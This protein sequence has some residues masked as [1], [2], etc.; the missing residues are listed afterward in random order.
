MLNI[1]LACMCAIVSTFGINFT[2]K[3]IIIFFM[4]YSHG[5]LDSSSRNMYIGREK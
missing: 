2:H 3:N 4:F 5:L 1:R